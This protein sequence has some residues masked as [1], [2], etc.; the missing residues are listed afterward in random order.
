MKLSMAS[1]ERATTPTTSLPIEEPPVPSSSSRSKAYKPDLSAFAV[2]QEFNAKLISSHPFGIFVDISKGVN[3]LLPK[4][5]LGGKQY[6]QLKTMLDNKS[7]ETIKI[8]LTDISQESGKIAGIVLQEKGSLQGDDSLWS[9]LQGKEIIGKSYN[10]TVI[11]VHNFGLF[12]KVEEYGVQG[13][14]PLSK[15]PVKNNLKD[16]YPPGSVLQVTVEDLNIE[17]KKMVLSAVPRPDVRAFVNFPEE[18]WIQAVIQNVN[19]FGI[20]VRPAGYDAVGLVRRNQIPQDLLKTLRTVLEIDRRNQTVLEDLFGAGDVVR[21]RLENLDIDGGKVEFSMLPIPKDVE[22]EAFDEDDSDFADLKEFYG[23]ID[24]GEPDEEEESSSA[25][26]SLTDDD[27]SMKSYA[28]EEEE[29][30]EEAVAYDDEDNDYDYDPLATLVWWR[31]KPFAAPEEEYVEGDSEDDDLVEYDEDVIM[32]GLD[33]AIVDSFSDAPWITESDDMAQG[34]WR[35]LLSLDLEFG[36]ESKQLETDRAEDIKEME[37]EIGVMKGFDED[38]DKELPTP[39][40][41]NPDS[42]KFGVY[43]N[44]DDFPEWKEKSEWYQAYEKPLQKIEKIRYGKKNSDEEWEKEL[45]ELEK[46]LKL[47]Q[48]DLSTPIIQADQL[49]FAEHEQLVGG[50]TTEVIESIISG[51]DEAAAAAAA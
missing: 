5:K 36:D 2:G 25:T 50:S 11:S 45:D 29:D 32:E 23:N 27:F 13:L 33:E 22:A 47:N 44:F 34:A 12:V 37:M 1:A 21:V 35:R 19:S 49:S 6:D 10:T 26:L 9:D 16:V 48:P 43:V 30:D 42:N 7:T 20:F 46:S 41:S 28:D 38:I 4:S 51:G 14:V 15:L 3:V 24:E 31:G 17:A 39:F 8:S 18:K 40:L